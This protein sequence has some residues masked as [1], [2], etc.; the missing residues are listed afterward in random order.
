MMLMLRGGIFIL[1]IAGMTA[2][3]LAAIPHTHCFDS[4]AQQIEHNSIPH[5]HTAATR[6]THSHPHSP[7]RVLQSHC[8][9]HPMVL[10]QHD[11]PASLAERTSAP[12]HSDAIVLPAWTHAANDG[13]KLLIDLRTD[14]QSVLT[15]HES[16]STLCFSGCRNGAIREV[17]NDEPF[18][19]ARYLRLR[20]LR[21]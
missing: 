8:H 19:N 7:Q 18:G 10:D 2:S 11:G 15:P 21:I 9:R 12:H 20:A 16:P 4:S 13:V 3:Q 1:L 14:F 17:S 6:H 5:F